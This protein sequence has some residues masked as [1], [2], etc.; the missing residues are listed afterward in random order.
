MIR[1]RQ[2]LAAEREGQELGRRIADSRLVLT[3]AARAVPFRHHH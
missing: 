3:S 2:M 1:W